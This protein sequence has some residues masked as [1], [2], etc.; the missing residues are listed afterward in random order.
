[1]ISLSVITG[2][3]P[4]WWIAAG[5]LALA[6]IAAHLLAR[7]R[8][9]RIE[10]PGQRLLE[11][12]V[13]TG[14]RTSRP[15]DL[16]ALA[17]RALALAAAALA[18][19][20]GAWVTAGG[21]WTGEASRVV[22]VLDASASMTR[23]DAGR[24]VFERAQERAIAALE[25][26]G[27]T[28]GGVVVA[29]RSPNALLPE[30]TA[31]LDALRNRMGGVG[32]TL[33]AADLPGAIALARSLAGDSQPARIVVCTDGQGAASDGDIGRGV[34]VIDCSLRPWRGNR[35]I[36]GLEIIEREGRSELLATL[37]AWGEGAGSAR[38]LFE[39]EGEVFAAA[40][41]TLTDG[42]ETSA[43]VPAPRGGEDAWRVYSARFESPDA[44]AW[45]DARFVVAPGRAAPSVAIVTRAPE[46]AARWLRAAVNPFDAPEHEPEATTPDGPGE[47]QVHLIA[48]AGGWS[49]PALDALASRLRSGAGAIWVIDSQPAHDSLAAFLARHAAESGLRL[50]E[51]MASSGG[52][53]RV[54]AAPWLDLAGAEGVIEDARVEERS[55]VLEA[56]DAQVALRFE[57]GAPALVRT[58]LGRGALVTL[59][60]PIDRDRSTLARSPAL[61]ILIDALL[62]ALAPSPPRAASAAIGEPLLL[63]PAPGRSPGAGEALTDSLGRAVRVAGEDG[64]SLLVEPLDA[65]GVVMMTDDRGALGAGAAHVAMSESAPV[66]GAPVETAS[67]PGVIDSE[68]PRSGERRMDLAPWLLLFAAGALLVESIVT[69]A[70]AG[71]E[72]AS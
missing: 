19:S 42:G 64:S 28:E 17:L 12:V 16:A 26:P 24:S 49:T 9:R 69:S 58:P 18:F 61:P 25:A 14:R 53:L 54:Q 3:A 22:V 34:E 48:G 67:A 8:A 21:V 57:N 72:V 47:A 1:M 41:A 62:R 27:V 11:E 10:F 55:P 63:H 59:H 56:D 29:R 15:R 37:R 45:D 5:A 43:A 68:P 50:G 35:A 20:G 40:E 31:N 23:V 60:A 70:R 38:V 33:E 51:E 2:I 65:P 30:M 36:T 52:G 44:A 6:P 66:A 39:Q 46:G 71:S 13:V 4:G 7:G 32:A